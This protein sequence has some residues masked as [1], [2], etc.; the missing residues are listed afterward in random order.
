MELQCHIQD[1]NKC[2]R[3][4]AVSSEPAIQTLVTVIRFCVSVPV[5][6]VQIRVH[7]PS[8]SMTSILF[9]NTL[10]VCI[11]WATTSRQAVTVDGRPCGMLATMTTGRKRY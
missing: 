4:P 10:W 8:V 1:K 2:S 3:I 7:A 9:T 5:L 11:R 6:S